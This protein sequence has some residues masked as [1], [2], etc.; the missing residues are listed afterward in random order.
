MKKMN[1]TF[2]YYL[3]QP[4]VVV[5]PNTDEL[6]L[7]NWEIHLCLSDQQLINLFLINLGHTTCSSKRE[8][9]TPDKQPASVSKWK[10]CFATVGLFLDLSTV[11]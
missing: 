8:P 2:W 5:W 11:V 9:T 6:L 4:F 10:L 3:V 1:E 7:S